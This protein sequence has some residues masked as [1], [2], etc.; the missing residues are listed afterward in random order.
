MLFK[1]NLTSKSKLFCQLNNEWCFSWTFQENNLSL[2]TS[3]TSQQHPCYSSCSGNFLWSATNTR[4]RAKVDV[5]L[6]PGHQ[7]PVRLRPGLRAGRRA[8]AVVLRQR[9]LELARAGHRRV[10][11]RGPVQHHAGQANH[12]TNTVSAIQICISKPKCNGM[13]GLMEDGVDIHY[14]INKI[15]CS[16]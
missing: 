12:P 3:R 14:R 11:P 1:V 7:G 15:P 2:I 9:R 6:H 5:R 10:H 13:S 4:E 8:E 16:Q